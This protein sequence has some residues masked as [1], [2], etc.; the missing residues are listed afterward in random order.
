MDI[1]NINAPF[2]AEVLGL[3]P[4]ADLAP[5]TC[6]RLRYAFDERGLLVFRA[7]HADH[8][9]QV[10]LS[11]MLIGNDTGV[12]RGRDRSPDDTFYI[13]NRREGAAA[14]YGRLPFH[15]DAMWS[16]DPPLVL[17]LAAVD[18]EPPVAPT[19]FASAAHAWATLPRDL[20]ARVESLRAVHIAGV[21]PRG[22]N[23]DEVLI[24]TF[25]QSNSTVTPIGFRHPRTG[26]T[27]LEVCEQMTL[28]V[29]G[30]SPDE[31]DSLLT[32]LFAHLYDPA[33]RWEHEW[34]DGDLVVW[35]NIAVHHARINVPIEGPTRTLR[36]YFSPIPVLRGNPKPRYSGNQ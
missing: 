12:P 7:L 17:S 3:D 27:V 16:D 22:E 19:M 13:S 31:S 6:R 2:G 32:E 36:K 23:S 29:E 28:E 5:E 9:F 1:E 15:S 35:D 33:Q 26:H 8:P 20:R 21:V 4:A 34:H 25:E 10:R 11:E 30:L 24:S 14:P 18:V